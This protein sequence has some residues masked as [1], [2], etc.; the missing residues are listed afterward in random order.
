MHE[1]VVSNSV[2]IPRGELCRSPPDALAAFERGLGT[3]VSR[4]PD[5]PCC[6]TPRGLSASGLRM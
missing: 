6:C 5:I 1:T 2:T 4:R 3:H